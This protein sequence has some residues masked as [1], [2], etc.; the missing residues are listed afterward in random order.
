MTKRPL[1]ISG[2]PGSGK[3]SLAPVMADILD[4]EFMNH[5]LTSRS[6]LEDLTGDI[7]QMRRLSHAQEQPSPLRPDWAYQKPGLF[8]WAFDPESAERRG[9]SE[10]EFRKLEKDFEETR[11]KGRSG[12]KSG[13]VILLDE[14]DK[15]E[16]D[17]PNDLLEPLDNRSFKPP[18]SERIYAPDDLELLIVMTTNQERDLPRAVI[19]RCVVLDLEESDEDDKIPKLADKMVRIARIHDSDSETNNLAEETLRELARIFAEKYFQAKQKQQRLPGTSEFLDAVNA[20][21]RLGFS[22]GH[23]RWQQI[24][25]ATLI[26][27]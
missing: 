10:E 24:I 5:T 20:S 12:S 7:D 22:P 27:Y 16:P 2:P 9:G 13:V 17:L 23:D 25:D 19:R 18:V 21:A 4:F 11:L 1:L 15:A 6:Q 3:S 26:K 14:I 8:W